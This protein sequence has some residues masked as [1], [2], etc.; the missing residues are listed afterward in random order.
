MCVWPRELG[1]NEHSFWNE[2]VLEISKSI[3]NPNP[4][5][6]KHR[7]AAGLVACLKGFVEGGQFAASLDDDIV[8]IV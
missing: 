8:R 4:A 2:R 5:R 3:F 1:V 6:M 7:N